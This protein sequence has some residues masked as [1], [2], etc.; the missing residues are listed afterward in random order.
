MNFV[1][2]TTPNPLA[3][4][5][6]LDIQIEVIFM[7]DID[8]STVVEENVILLDVGQQAGV[9]VDLSYDRRVLTIKPRAN[10][11]PGTHYQVQLIGG[12][13]GFR[14]ITGNYLDVGYTF[15]F[16]TDHTRGIEPPEVFE[17]E[18]LSEWSAPVHFRWSVAENADHYE[19]EVSQSNTFSPIV[20][21]GEVHDTEVTP[22]IDYEP[23]PYFARIRSVDYKGQK[24]EYSPMIRFY[25]T[26]GLQSEPVEQLVSELTS[27]QLSALQSYFAQQA[28]SNSLHVVGSTP[29]DGAVHV[30]HDQ[31][32]INNWPNA[33]KE[34]VIEFDDTIDPASVDGTVVYLVSDRN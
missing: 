5:V 23:G 14:D 26:G 8:V 33:L 11:N 18:D 27:E 25:Y 21:S 20:W 34:I 4:N 13:E 15:D 16:Y 32:L 1:L 3:R 7:V 29:K 22:V 6:P 31:G 28:P 12:K 10:L 17:P 30:A 2:R 24:S 9:P 19:L